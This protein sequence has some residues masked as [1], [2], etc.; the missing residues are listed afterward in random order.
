MKKFTNYI[1]EE[2]K[3]LRS[4]K[5]E[6]ENGDSYN[7][8]MASHLTDEEIKNYYKIGTTFNIGLGPNDNMQTVKSCII[9]ESNKNLDDF[10]N[11]DSTPEFN[12]HVLIMV[13]DIM[14]L[15]AKLKSHNSLSFAI[16]LINKL[17]KEY[18]IRNSMLENKTNINEEISTGI[19]KYPEFTD[20]INIVV[21]NTI[22]SINEEVPKITSKMPYKNQFLLEEV[23]KYLETLV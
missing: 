1:T 22:K 9:L 20:A 23:I 2:N 5:V 12:S 7:T 10:M 15:V 8:S 6:F 16:K 4:V 17:K 13:N 11:Y 18:N 21:K 3:P 14:N 19:E